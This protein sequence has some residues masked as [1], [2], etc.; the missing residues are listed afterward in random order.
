RFPPHRD[1]PS[2][3]RRGAC[4]DPHR[5]RFRPLVHRFHGPCP[6]DHRRGLGCERERPLR[7]PA[8][9]ARSRR[10]APPEGSRRGAERVSG[11]LRGGQDVSEGRK[12][13]RHADGSVWTS[14]P[15]LTAERLQRSARRLAL[16]EL[17]VADFLTSLTALVAADE[18]WVPVPTGEQALYLRPFMFA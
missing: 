17:P 4:P 6:V 14:R 13:F 3:Q 15:E 7:A 12:A 10:A 11:R 1:R 8:A 9:V 16:P 2:R 5:S 18:P